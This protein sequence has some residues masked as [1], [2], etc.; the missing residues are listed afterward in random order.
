MQT[1]LRGVVATLDQVLAELDPALLHPADAVRV[2][3]VAEEIVRRGAAIKTLVAGRA[4][5]GSEWA[6]AG[7]RSAEDWLAAKSGCGFK[8]AERLSTPPNESKI[9]PR[10]PMPCATER[11]RRTRPLK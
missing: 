9:F 4:T 7:Y 5:E 2:L 6:R 10:P 1:Q 8:E 3:D 11:S